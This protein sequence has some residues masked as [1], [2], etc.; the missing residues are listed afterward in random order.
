MGELALPVHP[1]RERADLVEAGVREDLAHPRGAELQERLLQGDLAVGVGGLAARG[2]RDRVRGVRVGDVVPDDVQIGH[3]ERGG[4][5]LSDNA[6]P[7]VA[8]VRQQPARVGVAHVLVVGPV[9]MTTPRSTA[10]KAVALP[11]RWRSSPRACPSA[12]STVSPAPHPLVMTVISRS[13]GILPRQVDGVRGGEL[14][15]DEHGLARPDPGGGQPPARRVGIDDGAGGQGQ[16]HRVDHPVPAVPGAQGAVR[17]PGA[18][19]VAQVP[20]EQ[21]LLDELRVGGHPGPGGGKP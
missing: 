19:Q 15:R 3:P 13:A 18:G 5:E 16:R 7:G 8:Q 6:D 17:V 1:G 12:R 14:G 21:H 10:R 4:G 20:G 9:S 2:E 11:S